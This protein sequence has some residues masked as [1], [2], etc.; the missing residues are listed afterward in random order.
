MRTRPSSSP[1]L[2]ESPGLACSWFTP[3]TLH[4]ALYTLRPTPYALHPTPYALRSTLYAIHST[5]YALHPAPTP[6]FSHFVDANRT[7]YPQAVRAR[8]GWIMS[9]LSMMIFVYM[10]YVYGVKMYTNIGKGAE[11][12]FLIEYIWF[13]VLD[14]MVYSW[15]TVLSKVCGAMTIMALIK[16]FMLHHGNPFHWFEAQDDGALSK[17]LSDDLQA[18]DDIDLGLGD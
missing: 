11:L 10:I 14:N 15:G 17:S 12:D 18:M 3:Y 7:G 1:S 6:I 9:T 2:Q 13:M 5:P 4:P 16:E 8:T